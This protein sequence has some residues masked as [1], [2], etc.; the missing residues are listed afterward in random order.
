M[1]ELLKGQSTYV[2]DRLS[3][4]QSVEF[5]SLFDK[6]SNVEF[7]V[8][9][10]LSLL[11]LVKEQKVKVGQIDEKLYLEKIAKQGEE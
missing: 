2:M 7:V 5:D 10:F 9:T 11:E 6:T 3:K 4:Q 8:T 1:I